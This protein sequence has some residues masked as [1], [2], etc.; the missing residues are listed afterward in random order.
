M[1]EVPFCLSLDFLRSSLGDGD[2]YPCGREG[3]TTGWRERLGCDTVSTEASAPTPG[4]FGSGCSICLELGE[5]GGLYTRVS[6][7]WSRAL[8]G[9]GARLQTRQ[10][11]L[12]NAIPEE[13]WQL[14]PENRV[15][16]SGIKSRW[17]HWGGALIQD[18]WWLYKRMMWRQTPKGMALGWWRQQPGLCSCK[19]RNTKEWGPPPEAGGFPAGSVVKNLLAMQGMLIRS[20]RS[21]GGGH[22]NPLQYSCLENPIE[23]GAWRATVHSVTKSWTRLNSHVC[24][25]K[26]WERQGSNVSRAAKGSEPCQ[27]RDFR[28]QPGELERISLCCCKSLS[29]EGFLK[30]DLEKL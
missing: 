4:N 26:S 12:V 7:H 11:S 3:G 1:I 5:A 23:R 29:V 27:L 20:G 19:L 10:F 30:A 21:P 25:T 22:G 15:F 14:Q 24:C 17:G 6:I 8:P 2:F 13:G 18:N 28:L 9:E 16:V